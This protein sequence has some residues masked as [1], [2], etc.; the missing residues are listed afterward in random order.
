MDFS[1]PSHGLTAAKMQRFVDEIKK[2]P[3]LS[4]VLLDA[5]RVEIATLMQGHRFSGD[6]SSEMS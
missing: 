4:G 1:I 3:D 5:V 6:F 2:H